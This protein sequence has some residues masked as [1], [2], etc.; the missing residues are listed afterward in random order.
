MPLDLK[1]DAFVLGNEL[2][3]EGVQRGLDIRAQLEAV[4]LKV[5]VIIPDRFLVEEIA[6]GDF[7]D[8][9]DLPVDGLELG[10]V[11]ADQCADGGQTFVVLFDPL[12]VF[13]DRRLHPSTFL[14]KV[15]IC[16]MTIFL[17]AQA[18]PRTRTSAI[19]ART[20]TAFAA[21]FMRTSLVFP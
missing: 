21:F 17:V 19:A 7:P 13:L 16:S 9:L 12:L 10:V 2:L 5:G 8:V 3:G 20:K 14:S 4:E 6:L 18:G 1:V 15:A 11:L